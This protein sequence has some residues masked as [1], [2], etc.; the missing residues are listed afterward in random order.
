MEAEREIM[1]F[2]AALF[3]QDK[4]G[5]RY[6]GVVSAVAPFGRSSGIAFEAT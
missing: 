6:P 3:M 2:Y 4:V 5:E 1:A